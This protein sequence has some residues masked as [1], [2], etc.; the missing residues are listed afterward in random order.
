MLNQ[1]VRDHFQYIHHPSGVHEF[2][3]LVA[4]EQSIDRSVDAINEIFAATASSNCTDPYLFLSDTIFSGDQPMMYAIS[5]YRE[6]LRQHEHRISN[7]LY[8]AL[9]HNSRAMIGLWALLF[10]KLHPNIVICSF[11]EHELE[12]AHQWLQQQHQKTS[13]S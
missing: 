11:R 5:R 3:H 9:V 13:T 1:T 2:R 7:G 10:S 8:L 4:S 12:V 6:V